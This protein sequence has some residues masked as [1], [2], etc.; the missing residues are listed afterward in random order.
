M[1]PVFLFAAATLAALIAM[2]GAAP[3]QEEAATNSP[4]PPV[5]QAGEARAVSVPQ[6]RQ[7]ANAAYGKQ[8]WP[9]FRE[10]VQ[11]LHQ[12]RPWN[13]DYMSLLVVAHALN[14]D[15][16]AAYEMM[17][18]MQ[19][20]GLS[21]DFNATDDTLFLRG[22]E[23]YEYIND[24]MV[25][26]GEPA[27]EATLKF[28]LPADLL[29]PT[30]IEWDATREAYLVSSARDGS[31]VQVSRDGEAQVLLSAN[32]DNGLWG[33]FGMTVDAAN[34][35]LW[36]SSA[37]SVNFEGYDEEDSGRSALF[38]FELD[39]L[40]LVKSYPVAEDGK[41]H[42]LGDL[43]VTASG[44]VYTVDTVLPIIYRLQKGAEQLRPF[45]A[46]SDNVSLRGVT[47][48]DDGRMLYIA[49]YEMG[50]MVLDLEGKKAMRLTGPETLNF[51]GIEDLAFW[52]NHLVVIQN[53]NEPQRIMRLQ[54]A[55]DRT[56]VE[57]VA[58]L[59]IA[60]PFFAYPNYGTVVGDELVFLANSHWVRKQGE[61]EPVRVAT[62]GIASAPDL[63]AP[64]VEKFWDEYY[65]SQGIERPR[66]QQ[67][68]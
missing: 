19:R 46:S 54:L 22:T 15:K 61:P 26:A 55:E 68:P 7:I 45:V 11:A 17:L 2:P 4:A 5:R 9:A 29:L 1:K 30:A 62:T 48:S 3:A 23:A 67:E 31:V 33:I 56:S 40:D 65:K 27:G 32:E 16:A 34:N 60:Q 51:G 20:Q 44:D 66:E 49:D 41:P 63:E 13:A 38:E 21:H 18:T 12:L 50:I 57:K 24:L 28:E 43:V 42:R 52:Q 37:A 53:G 10:A 64:D 59:A 6:L 25:R 8:D 58:P 14:H 36:L 47:A 35:R 39:S